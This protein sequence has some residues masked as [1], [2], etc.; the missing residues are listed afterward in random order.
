MSRFAY[1]QIPPARRS[2][3][4][5]GQ[6]GSA[7]ALEVMLHARGSPAQ[8]ANQ[9]RS[10]LVP[11]KVGIGPCNINI[12]PHLPLF[13]I[14]L[15]WDYPNGFRV[16]DLFLFSNQASSSEWPLLPFLRTDAHQVLQRAVC[17]VSAGAGLGCWNHIT[18][19]AYV[20][21]KKNQIFCR[22]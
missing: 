18:S 14:I 22:K 13:L 19:Q 20:S 15:P 4:G 12:F 16:T 5:F 7:H 2:C 1:K 21:R 8:R 17:W 6:P 9:S 10:Y 3:W 11:S